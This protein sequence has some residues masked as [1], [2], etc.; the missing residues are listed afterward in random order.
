MISLIAAVAK[1][2]A[3]GWRGKIPWHLPADLKHF[4]ETTMGHPVVMGRKTY[5][6]LGKTLPGRTN[7]VLTR[8][9]LKNTASPEFNPPDAA[10]VPSFKEALDLTD[11]AGEVFVIGGQSVY[12][13]A[14][15]FAEKIYL[16]LVDAEVD[17]DTFFPEFNE[18]EW[19]LLNSEHH[20]KDEKN[21]YDYTFL[22]Y[23]RKA[24]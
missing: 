17:G 7:I 8:T 22:V 10:T 3:I 23:E 24:Q 20:E 11:G 4:R 6:S 1:N 16:T 19:Q 13:E 14:L 9:H 2:R 21:H 15:P 5:E 12:E 18:S